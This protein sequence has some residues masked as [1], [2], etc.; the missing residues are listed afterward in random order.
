M[1]H[2]STDIEELAGSSSDSSDDRRAKSHACISNASSGVLHSLGENLVVAFDIKELRRILGMRGEKRCRQGE[3]SIGVRCPVE[4][5]I[6]GSLAWDR[7]RTCNIDRR[8]ARVEVVPWLSCPRGRCR[9]IGPVFEALVELREACAPRVSGK[10]DR[11]KLIPQSLNDATKRRATAL[12]DCGP[13]VLRKSTNKR[14]GN[15]AHQV[16][17]VWVIQ[18]IVQTIFG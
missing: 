16:A 14:A 9:P 15:Q 8:V 13:N 5:S 7:L 18:C 10:G 3:N 2:Q 12:S 11:V 4:K 6:F 1:T 17:C